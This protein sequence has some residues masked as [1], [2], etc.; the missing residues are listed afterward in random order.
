[1]N[2]PK[3]EQIAENGRLLV[4]KEFT[5]DKTAEKYRSVLVSLA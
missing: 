2:H 1:L 4:E 5:C 3:L